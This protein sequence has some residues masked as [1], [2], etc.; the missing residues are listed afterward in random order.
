MGVPLEA[1]KHLFSK[2]FRANNAQKSRPDGT[3]LGLFLAK[4]VIEDQGGTIIFSSTEG[5]GSIFGFE[6][7]MVKPKGGHGLAKPIIETA[8]KPKATVKA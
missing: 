6:L 4:R 1:Q 5:K 7:P 8:S 3:G 2:F